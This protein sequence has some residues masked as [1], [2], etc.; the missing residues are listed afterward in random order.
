MVYGIDVYSNYRQQFVITTGLGNDGRSLNDT[1][2]F[3]MNY[4]SWRPI[5]NV[6]T[7]NG[8]LPSMYDAIGGTDLEAQGG[9]NQASTVVVHPLSHISNLDFKDIVFIDCC[10]NLISL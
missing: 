4:E 8:P 10:L 9:P 3:D 6:Q 7:P 2:A 1:W 5:T